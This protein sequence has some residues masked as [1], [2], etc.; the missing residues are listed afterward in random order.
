MEGQSVQKW[1]S[2]A[3]SLYEQARLESSFTLQPARQPPHGKGVQG[4]CAPTI[5]TVAIRQASPGC[6]STSSTHSNTCTCV[7]AD[8]HEVMQIQLCVRQVQ[9]HYKSM[10]PA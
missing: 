4:V 1:L 7:C 2:V 8:N 3:F 10:W 5:C 9:R 6:C